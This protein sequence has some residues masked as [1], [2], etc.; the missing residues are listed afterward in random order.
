MTGNVPPT[1]GNLS[2]LQYFSVTQAKLEDKLPDSMGK[3]QNLEYLALSNNN[4][5][6][7]I[8][9]SIFNISSLQALYLDQNEFEGSLPGNL[10]DALPYLGILYLNYNR[11]WVPIPTSISNATY[12]VNFEVASNS[13]SGEVP[14]LA[15]LS[16]LR[17]FIID[18]NLLGMD[19]GADLN[20]ICTLTNG[21]KL[22][23]L[24]LV[25][26]KLKGGIPNCIG[27][28]SVMLTMF[29]LSDNLIEGI[30]PVGV[31]NLVN[32]TRLELARNDIHGNIPQSI[33]N[34]VKLKV[35]D[36]TGNSFSVNIPLSLGNLQSMTHLSLRN[37]KLEGEIPS[38]IS[39]CQNLLLLDLSG[40]NLVGLIPQGVISL[41][42]LSLL[43]DLSQNNLTGVLPDEID[44]LINVNVLNLGHNSLSGPIPMSIGNCLSMEELYLENNFFEGTI[45]LSLR[46]MRGLRV[47]NISSC[48]LTGQIPEFLQSLNLTSI[49]V[50]FNGLEGALPT[51]G[52]FSSVVMADVVGNEKLCGGL[53][54]FKLPKCEFENPRMRR[55]SRYVK[56]ILYTLS[57]LVAI[58][59]IIVL[60]YL[61]RHRRGKQDRLPSNPAK[62]GLLKV[63]YHSLSKATGGFSSMNLIGVGSFGSVYKGFLD[64]TQTTVAIKVLDLARH[65]GPKS[66]IAECEALRT[67]DIVIL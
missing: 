58:T 51:K 43:L 15:K 16:E 40:N 50:S 19:R 10:W 18:G 37:N 30:L 26:N 47:L 59:C 3:L 61:L 33:G 23:I 64:Q 1:I 8:P 36:L 60:V 34:I 48:R 28:L 56:V 54:Q 38:S 4:L 2:S 29:R 52:V 14:S 39:E 66:F 41:P 21:T 35:L 22:Q 65:E 46:L 13:I 17:R 6:G 12:L 53:P 31:G 57:V 27:N 42:S 63:S 24:T 11:F 20:F 9:S 55:L 62:D 49:S 32:L 67:L 7:S 44:K 25:Q 5:S 45:P